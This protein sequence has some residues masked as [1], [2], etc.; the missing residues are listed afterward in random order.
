MTR[1]IWDECDGEP[2]EVHTLEEFLREVGERFPHMREWA[3]AK[4][5][6]V[7]PSEPWDGF[8]ESSAYNEIPFGD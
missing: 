5:A 7:E 6:D 1:I 4:L 3:Q 2:I 8:A